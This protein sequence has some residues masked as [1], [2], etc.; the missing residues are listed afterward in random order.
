MIWHLGN[1]ARGVPS[2]NVVSEKRS[3]HINKKDPRSFRRPCLWYRDNCDPNTTPLHRSSAYQFYTHNRYCAPSLAKR[4]PLSLIL[5]LSPSLAPSTTLRPHS[6]PFSSPSHAMSTF[7]A[8][9][10]PTVSAGPETNTRRKRSF[11]DLLLPSL[12]FDSSHVYNHESAYL[13]QPVALDRH[14]KRAR[15]AP[16]SPTGVGSLTPHTSPLLNKGTIN[17]ISLP[18]VPSVLNLAQSGAPTT[19]RE[20]LSNPEY[21]PSTP[22][23]SRVAHRDSFIK[24]SQKGPL[25]SLR[26][27]RLLPHPKVQ[28]HAYRFPD[29]SENTPIWRESLMNWCKSENYQDYQQIAKEVQRCVY[30][31]SAPGLNILANVATITQKIPS[32]LNPVDQFHDL[33]DSASTDGVVTPPMSPRNATAAG[34]SGPLTFTPT[35]S[36]KL[37]QTIRQKRAGSHRKTNSFKAREMKKLLN[38][39]DVLSIDSKGKVEKPARKRKTSSPSSPQ[40]LVMKISTL[41]PLRTPLS[42]TALPKGPAMGATPPTSRNS[43]TR[44]PQRSVSPVRAVSPPRTHVFVL[45]EPRTPPMSSHTVAS[46]GRSGGSPRS[47]ACQTKKTTSPKRTSNRTCIS[48]LSSD[49]PCW[50]PSWTN[51]KQDQL[52]NSCGLRYK[53]TQTRCLN[54]TCR[55]IPSKGELAIMKANG[56]ITRTNSDGTLTEG[57]GCLFCNSMVEIREKPS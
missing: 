51:K 22:T 32:I 55:K 28:E 40:Q 17:P 49:S 43:I 15:T 31:D 9:M 6:S 57:L 27:L 8:P 50:R 47:E 23:L 4:A 11:D 20:S 41:S 33:S 39:R 45:N 30:S 18:P 53:K 7:S 24:P 25:P 21:I 16:A 10:V 29:T 38:N 56:K 3:L 42:G 52:C 26:H 12:G 37:V 19:L 46:S 2:R 35:L 14:N 48:C 54:E 5:T 34:R 13:F 1:A 44:T 36:E